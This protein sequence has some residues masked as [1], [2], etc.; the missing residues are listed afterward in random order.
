VESD[1]NC[2]LFFYGKDDFH[3]NLRKAI[4]YKENYSNITTFYYIVEIR[5]NIFRDLK[6]NIYLNKTDKTWATGLDIIICSFLYAI[7]I[8]ICK[9]STVFKSIDYI[10]LF[11]YEENT[12]SSPL[13]ILINENFNHCKLINPKHKNNEK[14][15]ETKNNF[16]NNTNNDFK[17]RINKIYIEKKINY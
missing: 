3:S 7:N 8:A 10:Y 6:K 9:N 4:P 1:D 16:N 11:I 17:R 14:V 5:R 15:F 12:L 13:M 2:Y